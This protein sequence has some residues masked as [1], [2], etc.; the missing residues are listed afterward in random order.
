MPEQTSSST[1]QSFSPQSVILSHPHLD[2]FTERRCS[3]R[4]AVHFLHETSLMSPVTSDLVT[5]KEHFVQRVAGLSADI[6]KES[7][8]LM[9]RQALN[10]L[11]QSGLANFWSE[12]YG[13]A[14]ITVPPELLR[15][16]DQIFGCCPQVAHQSRVPD[17]LGRI[18]RQQTVTV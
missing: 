4:N 10:M 15:T 7:S 18:W 1:G 5:I 16:K 6:N 2:S 8:L 12:D 17:D 11:A 13:P 9:W 14:G 3:L